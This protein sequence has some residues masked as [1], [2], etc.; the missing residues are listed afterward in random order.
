MSVFTWACPL[1]VMGISL[2]EGTSYPNLLV[3]GTA[4][5]RLGISGGDG[6]ESWTSDGPWEAGSGSGSDHAPSISPCQH[7]QACRDIK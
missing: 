4:F 1:G 6:E 2:S 5:L 3:I 7:D